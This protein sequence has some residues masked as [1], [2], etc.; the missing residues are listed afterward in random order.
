MSTSIL[1]DVYYELLR[2]FPDTRPGM[3]LPDAKK[4]IRS[5]WHMLGSNLQTVTR[6]PVM[7]CSVAVWQDADGDL[8]IQ[9]YQHTQW[10][11]NPYETE[12]LCYAWERGA[13]IDEYAFGMENPNNPHH[14]LLFA[15]FWQL[16]AEQQSQRVQAS[17]TASVLIGTYN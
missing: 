15:H 11:T 14:A 4:H 5:K 12:G 8:G 10:H 3:T 2:Q 7:D 1:W 17:R 6:E 16:I 9:L 13:S